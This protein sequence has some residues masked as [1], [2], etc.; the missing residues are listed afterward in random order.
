ML[1]LLKDANIFSFIFQHK[2]R[3]MSR[4]LTLDM[5]ITIQGNEQEELPER[6]LCQTRFLGVDFRAIPT[7]IEDE[8]G[9]RQE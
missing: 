1:K 5:A 7:L 2:V 6:V 4:S 8:N 3:D 9:Y